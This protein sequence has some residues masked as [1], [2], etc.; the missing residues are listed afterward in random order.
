MSKPKL[1]PAQHVELGATLKHARRLLLEAAGMCRGYGRLSAQL[2][3]A[4]DALTAPRAWLEARLVEQVGEDAMIAGVHCRE[5]Y[6]G[7]LASEEVED[8]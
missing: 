5:V 7:E 1:T 4:A 3:D 2:F 6:F 8:A